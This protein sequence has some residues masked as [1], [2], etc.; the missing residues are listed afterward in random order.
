MKDQHY[1]P[2]NASAP[3]PGSAIT[4]SITAK[5]S[6]KTIIPCQ[7]NLPLNMNKMIIKVRVARKFNLNTVG[8]LP[9]RL[10]TEQE[11]T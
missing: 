2:K 6:L 4:C 9:T 8:I 7:S 5:A 10:T 1:K 3:R 11:E